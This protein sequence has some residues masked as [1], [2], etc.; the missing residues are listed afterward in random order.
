MLGF[1]HWSGPLAPAAFA[2][3]EAVLIRRLMMEL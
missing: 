2:N 1:S 3:N